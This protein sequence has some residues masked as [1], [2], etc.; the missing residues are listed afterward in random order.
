MEA[1]SG[2]TLGADGDLAEAV[3]PDI[4]IVPGGTRYL[5]GPTDCDPEV[6]Q[7]LR[8]H[9]PKSQR[10]VSVCTGAFSWPRPGCSPAGV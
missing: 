7:W 2:V 10:V 9:A 1:P 5:T 3:A 4:L 8:D 6:V